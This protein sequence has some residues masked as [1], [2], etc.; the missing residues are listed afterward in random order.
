MSPEEFEGMD[1]QRIQ[2]YITK[3]NQIAREERNQ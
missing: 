2:L 1:F 3:A